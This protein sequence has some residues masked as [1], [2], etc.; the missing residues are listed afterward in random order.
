R[1]EYVA[2]GPLD[3]DGATSVACAIAQAVAAIHATGMA[4]G[5]IHAGTVLIGTDGR[6]VL[7]DARADE[8]TTPDADVRAIGAVLYCALTGHWPHAEAGASSPPDAARDESDR[9]RA[10]RPAP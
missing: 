6:V 8:A 5:N 3:A 7:S 2:D 1:R 9:L 10:P 4:H